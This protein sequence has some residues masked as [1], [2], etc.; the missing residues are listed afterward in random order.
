[1]QA[2][3]PDTGDV[4]GVLAVNSHESVGLEERRHLTERSEIDERCT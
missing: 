3:K 1:L 4:D 2:E